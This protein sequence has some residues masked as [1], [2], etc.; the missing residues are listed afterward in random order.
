MFKK[1][2]S[3]GVEWESNQ[4]KT[5]LLRYNV[6]KYRIYYGVLGVHHSLVTYINVFVMFVTQ[7]GARAQTQP[8]PGPQIG[9][10]WVRVGL[11]RAED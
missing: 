6:I 4:T 7:F 1:I 10:G 3:I 5:W 2:L 8:N 11:G 9:L